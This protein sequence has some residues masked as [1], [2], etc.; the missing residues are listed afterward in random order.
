MELD[1]SVFFTVKNNFDL[2]EEGNKPR[3]TGLKNLKRRL[4]LAYPKKHTYSFSKK[5]NIYEAQLKL[6]TK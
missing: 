6:Q 5:E 4:E 3:G 2:E 1:G